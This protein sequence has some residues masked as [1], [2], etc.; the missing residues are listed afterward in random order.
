MVLLHSRLT[1]SRVDKSFQDSKPRCRI[2]PSPMTKIHQLRYIE[3]L[4]KS[5]PTTEL[6]AVS[7]E[8]GRIVF[9]STRAEDANE[10]TEAGSTPHLPTP[11]AVGQLGGEADGMTGRIKDFEILKFTA[12]EVPN[13]SLLIVAGSSDGSIRLWILD[14]AQLRTEHEPLNVAFSSNGVDANHD[15][16]Q[17]RQVGKLFGTYETG[18]RITCLKAFIMTSPLMENG[19][20]TCLDHDFGDSRMGQNKGQLDS[21]NS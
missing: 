11:G 7:T 17:T 16:P 20:P 14:G 15:V 21:T 4:T 1:S 2:M 13:A 5:E 9:F 8:D 12:G 19:G 3:L 10:A 6:L 18:N